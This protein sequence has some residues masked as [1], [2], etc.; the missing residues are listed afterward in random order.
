ME[1]DRKST[2]RGH[3]F[4]ATALLIVAIA[5]ASYQLLYTQ[6][7]LQNPTAHRVTHLG[8]AFAVVFLSLLLKSKRGWFLILGLLLTSVVATGY[9]RYFLNDILWIR[10]AAPSTPD[11]VIGGLV[12]FLAFIGTYLM[13]GKTFPIIA[14]ISLAYIILGRYLPFPFT[15][16][17]VSFQHLG[18][19]LSTPGSLE[20]GVYGDILGISANYLFLFIFFGALLQAFGGLR[21]VMSLAQWVG[22]KMKSGPAAVAV[23]SSSLVGTITGSTAAN[24]TITGS[25]TIPMMKRAGYKPEVA[26]AIEAAAS[27]GGQIM[28]PIMGAAAMVMAG[29]S[30]IPYVQIVVAAIVPALLYYYGLFL[31]VELTARRTVIKVTKVPISGRQILQDAPTFLIPLGVLVFLLFQGYSLPFVGFWSIMSLIAIG[32]ISSLRRE[33]RLSIKKTFGLIVDGVISA[34]QIAVVSALI[35][36][37]ATN[38]KVSGLGIMLPMLIQDI[39]GGHLIIALLIGMV[40]SI[41]LG[42]GVPTVAA[43]ILVAIGLVP[44]LLAMGVPML[45]AHLFPFI[46]AIFSHLTPPVAIGSLIA[47][48]IA[49][50]DYWGTSKEALKCAFTAFLLPFF[51]VYAPVVILRPEGGFILSLAQITAIILGITSLQIGISNYFF[52]IL[53][54][55]ERPVFIL[56]ALLF[57][58]FVFTQG[59]PFIFA[60]IVFFLM[61]ATSQFTKRKR[62]QSHLRRDFH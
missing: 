24:I 18:V 21:F 36:I 12:V 48:R 31:Y 60:G 54:Q 4:I 46:F 8:F 7:L 37:V 2:P 35:G 40:S 52:G 59:Y 30:G 33:A 17:P 41:L 14:A 43:Y 27:N 38:I 19:W 55:Y 58:A 62:G 6:I 15:V 9:F 53:G 25:F 13:W 5:M 11:L 47:S 45:Q 56:A 42:M 28:P 1:E 22:T 39:S 51:L 61:A 16:A 10:S 34:S 3:R 44:A 23:V 49:G 32:L 57:L 29:F 26:G 20:E 50:A